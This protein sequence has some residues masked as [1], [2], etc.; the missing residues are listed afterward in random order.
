MFILSTV[1]DTIKVKASQLGHDISTAIETNINAKYANRVLSGVGLCISHFDFV[2]I[3]EGNIMFG[4]GCTYYKATF[5]LVVFR[6]FKGEVLL[7]KIKS[8]DEYSIRLSLGFF[9]DIYVA[10]E[11]LPSP[12]GYDRGE[13]T[14]FW[15]SDPNE[16]V[17]S[18]PLLSAKEERFYFDRHEYVRFAIDD[19]EFNEPEPPRP[20]GALASGQGATGPAPNGMAGAM[21]AADAD[22]AN[23]IPVY[24]IHASMAQSG[25]GPLAWWQEYQ[26]NGEDAEQEINQGA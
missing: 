21:S 4:D 17:I 5:R 8:C 15:L 6:P 14:W 22:T 19:D 9:D 23:R 3:S 20:R 11:A 26:D 1:H 24:K 2:S 10:W 7:G 16:D 13:A 12:C 25:L 18:D